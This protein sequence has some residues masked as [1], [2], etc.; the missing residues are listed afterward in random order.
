M[1]RPLFIYVN[2]KGLEAITSVISDNWPSE[3]TLFKQEQ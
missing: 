1:T 3:E 2:G